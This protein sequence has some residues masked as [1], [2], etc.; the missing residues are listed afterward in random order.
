MPTTQT[1]PQSRC[2]LW[3]GG[4]CFATFENCTTK[5]DARRSAAKIGLM[6]SVSYWKI[7]FCINF[8]FS[9]VQI[10][11]E[12]PSR[13]I[14][15]EVI[16]KLVQDAKTSLQVHLKHF[17]D[18]LYILCILVC[19]L[20][21][22]NSLNNKAYYSFSEEA[23]F[24]LLIKLSENSIILQ[25]QQ[26]LEIFEKCVSVW[27]SSFRSTKVSIGIFN[28]RKVGQKHTTTLVVVHLCADLHS[29]KTFFWTPC[30]IWEQF[31]V[32]CGKKQIN[33]KDLFHSPL[34]RL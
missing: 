19:L 28:E 25:L 10:F 21:D 1:R 6:N 34:H 13:K 8:T 23:A 5:A 12:H 11:N 32:V 9:P 31:Q 14:T 33:C 7:K 27:V 16:T 3:I 30:R 18:Q 24:N 17:Q 20:S 15:T 26:N 4:S 22:R 2:H 29:C